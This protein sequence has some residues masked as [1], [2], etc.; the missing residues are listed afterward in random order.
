MTPITIDFHSTRYTWAA[1]YIEFTHFL[2]SVFKNVRHVSAWIPSQ[3]Q[4]AIES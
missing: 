3:G 1:G 4:K 2:P